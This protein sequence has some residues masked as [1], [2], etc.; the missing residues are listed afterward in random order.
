MFFFLLVNHDLFNFFF[1]FYVSSLINVN[2]NLFDF[3]KN[4]DVLCL[5]DIIYDIIYLIFEKIFLHIFYI[6]FN[7]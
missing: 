4:F 6:F 2:C 7:R 5:T 3:Q 1:K